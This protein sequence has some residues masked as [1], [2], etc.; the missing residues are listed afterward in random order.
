[1][2]AAGIPSRL[3]DAPMER[4]LR[5]AISTVVLSEADATAINASAT[6]LATPAWSR[7]FSA[8]TTM[9]TL[10][11]LVTHIPTALAAGSMNAAAIRRMGTRARK[12]EPVCV[13]LV[14]VN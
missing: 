13:E 2:L 7:A 9:S 11:P 8:Q 1:M 12:K 10:R 4:A 6:S 3:L 14:A 5:F